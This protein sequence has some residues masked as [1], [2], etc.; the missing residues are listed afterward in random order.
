[1]VFHGMM[2]AVTV[3]TSGLT[4]ALYSAGG[5]AGS[6]S[7]VRALNSMLGET[8]VQT[9]MQHLQDQYGDTGPFVQVFDF[10]MN[11]AWQKAG[12]SDVSIRANHDLSGE[13]LAQAVVTAGTQGHPFTVQRLLA[14]LFPPQ[15]AA[16]VLL[17]VDVK[18]GRDEG[19]DF[20][21]LTDAFFSDTQQMLAAR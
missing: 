18:Y 20:R 15:L 13:Q 6:F 17:D 3:Y 19:T 16:E 10:A 12:K 2:L 4:G 1:M 21:K 14:S 5:G 7:T 9:E 11:D 8:N